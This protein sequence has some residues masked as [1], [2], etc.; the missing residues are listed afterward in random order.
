V[1]VLKICLSCYN[2][3]AKQPGVGRG[4]VGGEKNAV[5]G[6]TLIFALLILY[7]A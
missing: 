2:N 4:G 3:C 7:A 5:S 6:N 1:N